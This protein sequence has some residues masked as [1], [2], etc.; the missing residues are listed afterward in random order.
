MEFDER[1]TVEHLRQHHD[2]LLRGHLHNAEA[3]DMGL[4]PKRVT[5]QSL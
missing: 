5:L 4:I 2:V 1:N 3:I